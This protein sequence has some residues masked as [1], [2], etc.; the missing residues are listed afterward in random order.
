[1]FLVFFS[2]NGCFNSLKVRYLQKRCSLSN[3]VPCYHGVTSNAHPRTYLCYAVLEEMHMK[4]SDCE[5]CKGL[6][7]FIDLTENNEWI[8]LENI[9]HIEGTDELVTFGAP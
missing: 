2:E 7:L 1:M 6:P 9:R 5:N 4:T 3:I 8:L